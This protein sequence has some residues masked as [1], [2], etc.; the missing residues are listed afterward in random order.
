MVGYDAL[1]YSFAVIP[2]CLHAETV[3]V[4]REHLIITSAVP[5]ISSISFF[6]GAVMASLGVITNSIHITTEGVGFAFVYIYKKEK[7]IS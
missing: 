7:K 2:F 5:S 4:L 1:L 3:N 6:E